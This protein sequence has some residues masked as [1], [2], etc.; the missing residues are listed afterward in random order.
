MLFRF[1]PHRIAGGGVKSAPHQRATGAP[2]SVDA[3]DQ[4]WR[5]TIIASSNYTR[6]SGG[7]MVI[8]CLPEHREVV[9]WLKVHGSIQGWE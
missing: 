8:T 3:Y 6:A 4:T 2:N 1:Q 5:R 7:L 9:L